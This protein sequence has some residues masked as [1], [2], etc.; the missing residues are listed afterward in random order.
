MSYYIILCGKSQVY[1]NEKLLYLNIILILHAIYLFINKHFAVSPQ[2]NTHPLYFFPPPNPAPSARNP[3]AAAPLAADPAPPLAAPS[4]WPRK[5]LRA[6]Q[7]FNYLRAVS[8]IY[9]GGGGVKHLAYVK[10]RLSS[11]RVAFA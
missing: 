10:V 3:S 9:V 1:V 7:A 8:S 11:E 6:S 2:E 4:G 5:C